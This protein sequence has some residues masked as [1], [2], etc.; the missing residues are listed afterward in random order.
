MDLTILY[1]FYPVALPHWIAWLLFTL[2]TLGGIAAGVARG[3]MRGW[4]AGVAAGLLYGGAFLIVT[5]LASMV[6]TF[7]V[8]DL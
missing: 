4:I 1:T 5:I 6:I 7:F 8:H 2:A 3:R